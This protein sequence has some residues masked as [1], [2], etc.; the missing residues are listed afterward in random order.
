MSGSR[1]THTSLFS[2][3]WL[4]ID[5]ILCFMI[6]ISMSSLLVDTSTV[7]NQPKKRQ[8]R[9]RHH[10]PRS[11]A[12]TA[13][14][15]VEDYQSKFP[16]LTQTSLP[17]ISASLPQ[18]NLSYR[19]IA[20]RQFDL[21]PM[22]SSSSEVYSTSP[23]IP[24]NSQTLNASVKSALRRWMT[25]SHVST[26]IAPA[27]TNFARSRP[28]TYTR[29]SYDKLF[30][31]NLNSEAPSTPVAP[32]SSESVVAAGVSVLR[33]KMAKVNNTQLLLPDYLLARLITSNSTISDLISKQTPSNHTPK[34]HTTRIHNS[35][36][37]RNHC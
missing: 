33:S 26:P 9:R 37:I 19:E 22:A 36:P 28:T 31:R 21:A 15:L 34:R 25:S 13:E 7:S 4:P 3:L 6:P 32:K 24:K 18:P 11:A 12:S 1:S 16:A 20:A 17:V 5:M 29:T 23:S 8:N 35:R 2:A 27:P 10:T 30:S 14:S